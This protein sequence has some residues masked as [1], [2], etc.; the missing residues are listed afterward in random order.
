MIRRHDGRQDAHP[1]TGSHFTCADF[2]Q[3]VFTSSSAPI[4]PIGAS[5]KI[6]RQPCR[7]L[8]PLDAIPLALRSRLDP[9]FTF[10]LFGLNRV[11]P[12][13]ATSR[14][15]TD[16]NGWGHIPN[17]ARLGGLVAGPCLAEPTEVVDRMQVALQSRCFR[18]KVRTTGG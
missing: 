2:P 6:V 16:D 15:N 12:V 1:K 5:L 17:M 8:C 10:L 11:D 9:N 13:G 7:V 14:R 3:T 4:L 18:M